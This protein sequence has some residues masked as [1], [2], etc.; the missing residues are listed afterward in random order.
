MAAGRLLS[1]VGTIALAAGLTACASVD[2]TLGDATASGVAVTGSSALA[3]EL[4]ADGGV[5]RP[6]VDTA[7][8]DAITELTDASRTVLE[9]TPGDPDAEDRRDGVERALRDALDAVV[10]ARAA[11][12]R[13]EAAREWA[14][15]LDT[16]RDALAEVAP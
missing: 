2:D 11:V 4:Y 1:L 7:L 13:G 15:R 10:G 8:A 16:A 3:L 12:A 14:D 6:T 5:L 9:L